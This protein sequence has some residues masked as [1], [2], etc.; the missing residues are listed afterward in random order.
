MRYGHVAGNEGISFEKWRSTG[1]PITIALR[2]HG[3][4][5]QRTMN[6]KLDVMKHNSGF[7]QP[8]ITITQYHNN[9]HKKQTNINLF[10]RDIRLLKW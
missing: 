5:V 9:K 10:H 4:C 8:S 7:G 6:W 2:L 1:G 3:F